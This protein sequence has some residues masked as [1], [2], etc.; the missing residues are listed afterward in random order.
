M[1]RQFDDWYDSIPRDFLDEDYI[2]HYGIEYKRMKEFPDY[3]VT[4]SGEIFS[5]RTG[6]L[7]ELATWPNQYGHL[8]TRINYGEFKK[9]VSIH[10]EVA[11]AF[12]ERPE[13][14]NV[15]RHLND[16]PT[17][18]SKDN[19]C[20]GTQADNIRDCREHERMYARAVYCLEDG[21]EYYSCADLA[22]EL[23]VSKAL[24]TRN[25]QSGKPIKGKHYGYVDER[26][27]DHEHCD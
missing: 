1:S 12:L 20:W 9:T 13:G 15:V 24:I 26:K 5:Y 14:C 22:R 16:D 10:R 4:S 21:E 17:D 11:K 3:Y 25:C 23:D 7:K 18:N 8:Y 19:L 6:V 27:K 2:Y